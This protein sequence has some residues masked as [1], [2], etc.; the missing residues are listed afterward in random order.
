MNTEILKTFLEVSRTLHFGKAAELLYLTQSAVSFRIR[1]LENQLGVILFTRKRNQIRLT[2]AG[3]RLVPYANS[4]I[5][6][7]LSAKKNV[8]YAQHY[9]QLSIGTS[10]SVWEAYLTAWLKSIYDHNEEKSLYIDVR[11]AS[12]SLLIKQL[13]DQQLD[14]L[15]TTD[16]PTQMGEVVSM[17]LGTISLQLF[18]IRVVVL[19]NNHY[20]YIDLEWGD[21][22]YN[23]DLTMTGIQLLPVLMTSSA[24]LTLKLLTSINACAFLPN[25]WNKIYPELIAISH[26][27]LITR[28]LYA[29]WLQNSPHH[30]QIQKLLKWSINNFK[31]KFL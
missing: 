30:T 21:D 3:I 22:V 11:M 5:N 31:F 8:I 10:A 29:I 17:K 27:P 12:R 16:V 24:H 7:W 15:I 28:P 6:F 1:Q 20:N 18:R 4:M 13:H 23:H 25:F 2:A 26:I 9:Y 14:M 19:A